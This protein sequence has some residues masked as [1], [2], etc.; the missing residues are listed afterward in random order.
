MPFSPV[1]APNLSDA[2]ATQIRELIALDILR[3]GDVLPGER[4]LATRMGISRTS[5]RSA[6]QALISEGV[7]VSQHGSRLRVA[8]DLGRAIADPL[9]QILESAPNVIDDY[10]SFRAMLEGECAAH[11]AE[12]RTAIECDEIEHAH[13]AMQTAVENNDLGAAARADIEF[14]MLIVEMAGNVVSI[15]ISR[16]LQQLLQ[17]GVKRSHELSS[18]DPSTWAELV[19]Q[20]TV[21]L[22]AIKS[23][24]PETARKTM[25][26]HL[27]FQKDLQQRDADYR[28][29]RSLVE[30]RRAWATERGV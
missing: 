5:V 23:G 12:R 9:V 15:Q 29:R 22:N 6:L 26:S 10:L 16:A 28:H 20:H 7:L 14:H 4:D 21:I 17:R 8:E 11:V 30:K 1:N 2:A 25:R 18:S 13:Y 27:Q 19:K 3:P 24:N